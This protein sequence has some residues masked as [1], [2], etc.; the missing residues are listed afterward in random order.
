LEGIRPLRDTS[1][2]I[3]WRIRD[4]GSP[5]GAGAGWKGFKS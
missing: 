3:A 2:T 5:S 4:R 1:F